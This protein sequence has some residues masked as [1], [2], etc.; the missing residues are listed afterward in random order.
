MSSGLDYTIEGDHKSK[1][2]DIF[3]F[4]GQPRKDYS[5]GSAETSTM[6]I[7]GQ[8]RRTIC[9]A[10]C[11]RSCIL[12]APRQRFPH[13]DKLAYRLGHLLQP[14]VH[15]EVDCPPLK[16]A[17]F[18][19]LARRRTGQDLDPLIDDPHRPDVELAFPAAVATSS[20]SI[21]LGTLLLGSITVL[22]AKLL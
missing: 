3:E 14:L 20:L 7:F 8:D 1:A 17:I 4:S 22:Q 15:Q 5:S 19:P 13:A 10:H 9:R 12:F 6:S 16:G 21:R 2:P 11:R 18:L